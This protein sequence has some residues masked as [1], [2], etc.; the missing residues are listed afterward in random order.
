MMGDRM[1]K[2]AEGKKPGGEG[3]GRRLPRRFYAEA[4]IVAQDGG[5]VLVLDGRPARTPARNPISVASPALAESVAAEWRAQD[6]VIDP[7]S[8]PITRLVNA[9]IDHVAGDMDFVAEDVIEFANCDLLCYRALEPRELAARQQRK[10]DP[11][12]AWFEET[13]GA[14]FEAGAGLVH[15]EQRPETL[16]RFASALDE[17]VAGDPVRLAALHAITTLTGSAVLALA[18]G[19]AALDVDEAWRAAHVDEDWQ[20]EHWGED[21]E[22]KAHRDGRWREMKAAHD[23][24]R[25]TDGR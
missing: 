14:A 5:H 7:A 10:W 2:G 8:M 13:H 23:V 19:S 18:L 25:H 15:I 12:L 16:A 6:G 20:I 24:L 3:A 9:A 1:T 17:V 22:A 11:V 21:A 4:G